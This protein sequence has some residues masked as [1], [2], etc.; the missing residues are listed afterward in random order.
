MNSRSV[1]LCMA[2]LALGM[3][4][5]DGL[6][7]EQWNQFRGPYGNGQTEATGLPTKWSESSPNIRWKT[8]IHGKGW[9]SP[10][11]WGDQ[12]WMTTAPEDGTRLYAV[13]ADA[14]TG[15]IKHDKLVFEV[16]DPQYCHPTN[17][18]ASCTPFVEPGR[19]YVHFGRYGTACLNS[20]TGEVIWERRDF[21][22]DHFR[23]PASSPIVHGDL[24][25]L[26]FDGI[27]AQ[28]VVA[29]KKSSGEL[30]WRNLRNIDYGTDV[31][32]RKK[33]YCTPSIVS[34]GGREMLVSPSA[35]ETIAYDPVSGDEIWRV[36][37]GG[38]NAAARP[39]FENG[40]LYLSAG[41][42]ENSL[43]AVRPGGEG[44]IPDSQ[45]AWRFGKSVPRRA[46]QLVLG[47]Y[48]LMADDKGVAT[49][50]DAATGK[51]TWQKRLRGEFWS[52]P[53]ASGKTAYF[54]NK[55]GQTYVVRAGDEYQQLAVNQLDA[56]INA[57]PA[58]I[59]RSII[60][61]TFTHLY[62]IDPE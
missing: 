43:I 26:T 47:E 34:F 30:A 6:A 7:G 17:S 60:I 33:A 57:S 16:E 2:G 52:S 9:S 14:E 45:I 49:C 19:V 36:R 4:S 20:A 46:S 38:M 21:L 62:R 51:L 10:V 8:P 61:R 25:F 50:L 39:L 40:L 35:S 18:Y 12:I 53:I 23:G 55:A 31:G 28:Y 24:V 13:C 5:A 44:R 22:C 56:G 54:S 11:V 42:G 48:F 27:D 59:D 3:G 37:H 1:M 15:A 58:V 41:D 32:D 29:L